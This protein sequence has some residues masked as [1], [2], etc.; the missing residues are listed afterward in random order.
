MKTASL[1]LSAVLTVNSL[2]AF[3]EDFERNL[4]RLPNRMT[5][6]AG[7]K[8]SSGD[9]GSK[10][11]DTDAWYVPFSLGYVH[12]HWRFKL[13]VPYLTS[14]GPGNVISAGT[15]TRVVVDKNRGACTFATV[16]AA[17]SSSCTTTA[18]T[19]PPATNVPR[20]TEAGLGDLSASAIY[21]INPLK[22]WMPYIDVGAKIKFPTADQNRRLGTGA[23]DY[24]M[25]G[26]LYKS[27][28]RFA[29]F[30]GVAYTFKGDIAPSSTIPR[31]LVLDN[32]LGSYVGAEYRVTNN[33]LAGLSV[34]YR[35][36]SSAFA[37]DVKE[38]SSYATWRVSPQLSVTG[39]AGT[40]FTDAT[41]DYFVGLALVYGFKSP[42]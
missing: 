1:V 20:I 2:G 15:D 24:T 11:G 12:N 30:G 34:D 21:G 5:L 26:D 28:G 17:N 39:T 33:W 16:V 37:R 7:F 9:Y 22:P 23:Y 41:P 19:T 8:F 13:I 4:E 6:G 31:G 35:Q 27:F 40:G 18:L 10:L 42:L 38:F 14:T 29:A 25:M 32:V 3:A 36:A